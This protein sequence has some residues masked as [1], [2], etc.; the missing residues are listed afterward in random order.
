MYIPFPQL[1]CAVFRVPFLPPQ[2]NAMENKARSSGEN[3]RGLSF[4]GRD[5]RESESVGISN[6]RTPWQRFGWRRRPS[7]LGSLEGSVPG[8]ALGQP[9]VLADRRVNP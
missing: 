9:L 3:G 7:S 2:L 6:P 8:P 5:G 4:Q 1:K